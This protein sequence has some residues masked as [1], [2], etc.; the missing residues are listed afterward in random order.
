ML[1]VVLDRSRL[2][3]PPSDVVSVAHVPHGMTTSAVRSL[4]VEEVM[5]DSREVE[6]SAESRLELQ[7]RGWKIINSRTRG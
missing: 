2:P 5:I 6:Q 4:A 3:P 7:E 1:S